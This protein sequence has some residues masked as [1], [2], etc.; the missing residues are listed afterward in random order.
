MGKIP[1]VWSLIRPV[2]RIPRAVVLKANYYFGN[3]ERVLWLIG[4]GRS[5]TTWLSDLINW[6][7]RYREMF[8][9]FHP[10]FVKG[11]ACLTPHEYIRPENIDHIV[12]EFASDIFS[13][14]YVGRRV[15]SIEPQ[16][17]YEGLLIKDIFANLFARWAVERFPKIKLIW[18]IRN[19]FAV[20]LSKY[21]T[22]GWAWMTDPTKFL[23]QNY[24]VEDYLEEFAGL[25]GQSRKDYVERQVLIW[26]IIHSVP[27]TQFKKDEIFTVFYEDL[28]ENPAQ[29]LSRIF[30]YIDP[31]SAALSCEGALPLLA[32]PSR[33]ATKDSN[34]LTGKSPINAWKSELSRDQISNGLEILRFFGLDRLYTAEGL[35]RRE[36]L[37][38]LF[39]RTYLKHR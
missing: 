27:M 10:G 26:S 37:D 4:D 15:D 35:P 16:L 24:L 36:V 21:K 32:R 5:G 29:E 25:I 31:H 20:A 7:G 8:E 9:P 23:K 30:N 14:K 2:L 3:Y 22:R 18:I 33:M 28:I 17:T 39:E 12:L 6:D 38:A 34:V 1:A 13:G 11:A 19:P